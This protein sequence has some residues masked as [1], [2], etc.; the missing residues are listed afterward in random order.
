MISQ[1]QEKHNN[2]Y[3]YLDAMF[4]YDETKKCIIACDLTKVRFIREPNVTSENG[5]LTGK[6]IFPKGSMWKNKKYLHDV[7]TI[8]R[9]KGAFKERKRIE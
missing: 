5:G 7:D 9:S 3:T 6:D 1:T 2:N 4:T 8:E